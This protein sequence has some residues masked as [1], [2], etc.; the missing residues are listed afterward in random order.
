MLGT[1]PDSAEQSLP[2]RWAANIFYLQQFI[3]YPTEVFTFIILLQFILMSSIDSIASSIYNV[4]IYI[5]I[6]SIYLSLF[7]SHLSLIYLYTSISHLSS[8]RYLSITYASIHPSTY[9]LSLSFIPVL[10]AIVAIRY[11]TTNFIKLHLFSWLF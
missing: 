8:Y 6:L 11:T 10:W 7:I 2:F 9:H 3:F 1:L 4:S 5:L